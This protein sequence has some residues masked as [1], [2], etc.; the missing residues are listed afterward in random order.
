MHRQILRVVFAGLIGFT[1]ACGPGAEDGPRV[2]SE[3]DPDAWA[4]AQRIA[5]ENARLRRADQASLNTSHEPI[6]RAVHRSGSCSRYT[7]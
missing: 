4:D 2:E 3:P 1:I 5:D 6:F 7:L